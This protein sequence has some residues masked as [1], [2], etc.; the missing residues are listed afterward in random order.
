M[1]NSAVRQADDDNDDGFNIN[2]YI[3]IIENRDFWCEV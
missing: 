1:L 3:H 2:K